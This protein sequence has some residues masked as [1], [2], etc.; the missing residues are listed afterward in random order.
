MKSTKDSPVKDAHLL[1]EGQALACLMAAA[2]M[3]R[4]LLA[5]RLAKMKPSKENLLL[6]PQATNLIARWAEQTLNGGTSH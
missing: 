2:G 3:G 4:C 1:T 5:K 6:E